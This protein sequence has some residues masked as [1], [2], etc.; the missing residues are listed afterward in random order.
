[1]CRGCTKGAQACPV[2]AVAIEPTNGEGPRRTWAVVDADRCLG[3]GVCEEVCRWDARA[4]EER[5]EPPYIPE[6]TLERAAYMAIERG[7]V[8]DLLLDN[9]GTK[10]APVAAATVR[11]IE[12]LPPWKMA[13]A[14]QKLKSRFVGALLG[15]VRKRMA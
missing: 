3:C 11:V 13:M 6:D 4:M 2:D 14:N 15:Q 5:D 1:M 7:K 10:L 8:G 12:K 9:V